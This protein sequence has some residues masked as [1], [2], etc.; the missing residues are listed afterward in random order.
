MIIL[1]LFIYINLVQNLPGFQ[2]LNMHDYEFL[3]YPEIRVFNKLTLSFHLSTVV[4][5]LAL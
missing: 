4:I 3:L 1:I 5:I 2:L